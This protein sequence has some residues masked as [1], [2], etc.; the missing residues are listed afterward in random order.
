M[1]PT[2]IPFIIKYNKQYRFLDDVIL[3]EF[4]SNS[5]LFYIRNPAGINDAFIAVEKR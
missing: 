4:E 3:Q 5:L 1:R 2:I